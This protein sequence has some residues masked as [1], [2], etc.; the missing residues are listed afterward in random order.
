MGAVFQILPGH[1]GFCYSQQFCFIVFPAGFDGGFA[2][3][4]V[5]Q[6]IPDSISLGSAAVQQVGLASNSPAAAGESRTEIGEM[7]L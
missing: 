5:Q 2:G 6:L 3:Y 7:R 4:G 1:D